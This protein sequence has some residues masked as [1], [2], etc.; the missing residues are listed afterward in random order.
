MWQPRLGISWDVNGD[1]RSVVRGSAGIYY[2]RLASLNLASVRSTNGS[3][4]QTAAAA[5]TFG[6]LPDY[7]ELL[8]D[9]D[10]L[11]IPDHPN[12]FVMDKDWQAPRTISA[13]FS[14]ERELSPGFAASLAYTHASTDNLTRFVDRNAAVFGNPWSTGIDGANGVGSMTTVESSAKSRYN[15]FTVG[16]RR[17][18]SRDFQFQVNYTLSYD[19]SDDDNERDPFT[20]RYARADSIER[21]YNWSDRDQ[22]H[23][24]NAWV[25]TRVPGDIYI[26]NRISAYS[27]QPMSESCGADNEGTGERALVPTDRICADGSILQRNTLRKDNAFFSWDIRFSKPFAMGKNSMEVIFEIFNL[28]NTDNFKDPASG[29]LFLNFD[30]TL[31]GGLGEPR[32]AQAGVRYVF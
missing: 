17:A 18:T 26:N 5:S 20:F 6:T 2:A 10:P 19:K 29:S 30:G 7:G 8:P 4:S 1:S 16:L 25:L 22:R 12:I 3:L 27:A 13:T 11:A 21:E 23:R 14:Y 15:G 32:Q 9:A 31:R 24:F 28:F